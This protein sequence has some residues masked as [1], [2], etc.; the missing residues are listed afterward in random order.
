MIH[1]L[2]TGESGSGKSRTIR[3][4]IIPLWKR[5]GRHVIVC[6]PLGQRWPGAARIVNRPEAMLAMMRCNQQMVGIWDECG[7]MCESESKLSDAVSWL[8]MQSRNRGHL[9]YFM[10]Q[11]AYQL[12]IGFRN[13]CGSALVFHQRSDVD[14]GC[15]A[16]LYGDEMLEANRLS[17]GECLVAAP[18]KKTVKVRMFSIV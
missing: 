15:L 18:M 13:Q 6:D 10:A 16:R 11:R 8:A 2:V 7:S 4:K 12:P 14:R 9:I 17:I 1:W 5:R 3:E